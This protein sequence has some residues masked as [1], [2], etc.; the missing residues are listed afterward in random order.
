MRVQAPVQFIHNNNQVAINDIKPG[1]G[2]RIN[3]LGSIR[4]LVEFQV[5]EVIVSLHRQPKFR[6][7]EFCPFQ[8]FDVLQNFCGQIW[9]NFIRI[10][11]LFLNSD[12]GYKDVRLLEKLDQARLKLWFH[13]KTFGSEFGRD[14]HRSN[15]GQIAEPIDDRTKGFAVQ[16]HCRRNEKRVFP[17]GLLPRTA[18]SPERPTENPTE[19]LGMRV[20][21][22]Y[23]PSTPTPT[24]VGARTTIPPGFARNPLQSCT[25]TPRR[26]Q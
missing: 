7:S 1:T 13:L 10:D 5:C 23:Q 22:P 11:F 8:I 19:C 24:P 3:S 9:P 14:S 26:L 25:R 15:Y 6:C 17:G 12:L 18:G 20:I 2:K 16:L 4:L 21:F